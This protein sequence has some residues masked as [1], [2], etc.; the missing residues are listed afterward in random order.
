[1]G[2]AAEFFTPM[3]RRLCDVVGVVSLSAERMS[4]RFE[5]PWLA[6]AGA[7]GLAMRRFARMLVAKRP[8]AVY[9][10]I[11][12]WGL[13]LLRDALIVALAKACRSTPVLHLHGAQ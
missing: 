5:P 2:R 10:P 7:T 1:M 4:D 8:D 12:Q 9:L 11:S 13:P 3:L 6:K